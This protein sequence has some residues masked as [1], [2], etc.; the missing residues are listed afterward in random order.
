MKRLYAAISDDAN[1]SPQDKIKVCKRFIR[2]SM[3]AASTSGEFF[4]I[5]TFPRGVCRH[6]LSYVTCKCKLTGPLK[7]TS[8]TEY[9]YILDP[10]Q[11]ITIGLVC[12]TWLRGPA[13]NSLWKQNASLYTTIDFNILKFMRWR[14]KSNGPLA[15][16]SVGRRL[17]HFEGFQPGKWAFKDDTYIMIGG[18]ASVYIRPVT[19]KH[20][21]FYIYRNTNTGWMICGA[22]CHLSHKVDRHKVGYP[23]NIDTLRDISF[24]S[25]SSIFQREKLYGPQ[26]IRI[27][28]HLVEER[29][30]QHQHMYMTI[31]VKQKTARY[32]INQKIKLNQDT[33]LTLIK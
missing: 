33:G 10:N 2:D 18:H 25:V 4:W 8:K 28:A 20:I 5:S 27:T 1:V 19:P 24:A 15:L 26:K 23:Q 6:I 11:L 13:L 3:Q 17:F 16:R 9:G 30:I 12:K 22:G 31:Q 14:Y 21:Q 29:P 7:S 32:R